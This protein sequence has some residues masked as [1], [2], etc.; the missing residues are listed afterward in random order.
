MQ[1]GFTSRDVWIGGIGLTAIAAVILAMRLLQEVPNPA[2]SALL[3]LLVILITATAVRVRIAVSVCVIATA[4]FNFFLLPPF[5]TFTL[6]DP[7]N[8]VALF[9]VLVVAVIASQLSAAAR[10]RA[11]EAVGRRDELARLLSRDVLLMSDSD[12]AISGLARSVARR[13]DLDVVA[14]ALPREAD[15]DVFQGVPRRSR[16]R[17]V[18]CAMRSRQHRRPLNSTRTRERMPAI[19]VSREMDA[20]FA[21]CRSGSA[22][23]LLACWLQVAG[24]SSRVRLMPS[25]VSSRSQSNAR[26]CSRIEKRQN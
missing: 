17:R 1:S 19:E 24:R 4:A 23:H 7:Q 20:L 10:A 3:L 25:L 2:I 6:A 15:W 26:N 22:P 12:E 16:S 5:Y 9:V 11:Q 8:W 13:F 21:S 18:T 14:I